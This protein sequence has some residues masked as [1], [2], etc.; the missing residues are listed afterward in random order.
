[1][2]PIENSVE[3][4]TVAL[5]DAVSDV[6]QSMLQMSCT[7]S[8]HAPSV[9]ADI[10]ATITFSGHLESHCI[11][12]FAA[13]SAQQ[14]T[15]AFLGFSEPDHEQAIMA[16]AVGELCNMV[17]GG[18]KKRLGCPSWC[19]NL[20][21]P[22]IASHPES[23][24]CHASTPAVLRVYTFDGAAFVVSLTAPHEPSHTV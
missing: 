3:D 24:S 14:L 20:S 18:W 1:M 22:A 12:Q 16:D 23:G 13:P 5:D 17:A 19:A 2:N 4:W 21:V 7:P 10:C 11:V 8:L 15:S 6:F 9:C